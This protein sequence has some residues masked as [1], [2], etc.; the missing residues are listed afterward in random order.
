[1]AEPNQPPRP[2]GDLGYKAGAVGLAIILWFFSI[3]TSRFEADVTFPL[4][5]RNIRAG[6]TLSEEAPQTATLRFLGTG[7]ALAKLFLLRPFS[8]LKLV[9]DLDRVQRRHVFYLN[10]YLRSN[11]QRIVIPII[12]MRENLVFVE[13][14]R[15]DSIPILLGDYTERVVP[16]VPQVTIDIASGHTQVGPLTIDPPQVTVRGVV[17]AVSAVD[18][19]R[20]MRQ[21]YQDVTTAL[22]FTVGLLHPDPGKVLDVSP[23]NVT[24]HANVQALGERRIEEVPVHVI[25]TP[26]SLSVFVSPSTVALTLIGGVNFLAGV[27]STLVRVVVD[28]R[29]Q[30]SSTNPLVV[31]QVIPHPYMVRISDVVPR[32]L[33]LISTRRNQ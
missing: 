21:S 17:E 31:P 6:K 25:N 10:D 23:V 2:Y 27:D 12:G 16:V 8:N 3:S 19:V 13:V 29:E 24:I 7:R 14:V 22:E 4:E 26:R 18:N 1:M 30:F 20:T 33:E 5:I 28:Y 32:Q 11:P 9:L 15:P